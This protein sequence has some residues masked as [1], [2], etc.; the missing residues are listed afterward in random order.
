M[1]IGDAC[2]SI[3][4]ANKMLESIAGVT[5]ERNDWF[6]ATHTPIV[7]RVEKNE[8]SQDKLF[9]EIFSAE[10][11]EFIAVVR[12]DQGSGK[13]QLIRWLK[14]RY[15]IEIGERET[16][17]VKTRTVMI[18]RRSGSLKDALVQMCEQLPE[19]DQYL[20]KVKDA[21][22]NLSHTEARQRLSSSMFFCLQ[23]DVS[24]APSRLLRQLHTV[25]TNFG[26]MEHLIREG[27][28]IDLN[29]KRLVSQRRLEDEDDV[30]LPP[31]KP[32]DFNFRNVRDL[33]PDLWDR[34][35][36]DE[37]Q[38]EAAEWSTKHLRDA[39][40]N[41]TGLQKD[42]LNLIFRDIRADLKS[43]NES[44]VLFIEDV[45]TLGVLD[46]ELVN[47]VQPT[48]DSKLCPMVSVLGMTNGT[49]G[50]LPTNLLD[51]I[52]LKIELEIGSGFGSHDSSGD[53]VDKFVGRYLNALRYD[54]VG[55]R[56]LAS[57]IRNDGE[58]SQSKCLNCS[59]RETCF[60]AFGSVDIDSIQVGLYPLGVGTSRR[61]LDGLSNPNWPR[62]PR[63][64]I[65]YVL[66]KILRSPPSEW[67]QNPIHGLPVDLESPV[68]LLAYE[69]TLLESWSDVQKDNLNLLVYYWTGKNQ[70]QSAVQD[71]E[72]KLK[73]WALPPFGEL[74]SQTPTST[75]SDNSAR[76]ERR[77]I[78]GPTN[79]NRY[80]E[81]IGHLTGWSQRKEKLQ[82]P[83]IFRDLLRELIKNSVDVSSTRDPS[84]RIRQERFAKFDA[85]NIEIEDSASQARIKTPLT[86]NFPRN[87]ETFSLLRHLLAYRYEGGD[88]WR[89]SG[90]T[91]GRRLYG[92]WIRKNSPSVIASISLPGS[93]PTQSVQ[94]S[95][96]FLSF[97]Y[98]FL[99]RID[100]PSDHANATEKFISFD[101]SE[102]GCECFT[103]EL[104]K[105]ANELPN[106]VMD[107]RNALLE[108]LSV[109]QDS[110]NVTYIDPRPI[111]RGLRQKEVLN[112]LSDNNDINE[113]F[114]S[115]LFQ[116][117]RYL[118]NLQIVDLLKKEVDQ[119]L[120]RHEQITE[121]Y[122]YWQVSSNSFKESC[123]LFL[124]DCIDLL[125]IVE[126]AKVSTGNDNL[127]RELAGM[128][129]QE[130]SKR[131]STLAQVESL[132]R[133]DP[134]SLLKC[135][136]IG[137][138]QASEFI[139]D[140]DKLLKNLH[141]S[142]QSAG[143]SIVT[144]SQVAEKRYELITAINNFVG[145]LA[146]ETDNNAK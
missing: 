136:I 20:S 122:S 101:V 114:F 139:L 3:S 6:L 71:L 74:K 80:D 103:E 108:E 131:A 33:D 42:T 88:S 55:I 46:R 23:D 15:D 75:S 47:A 91:E 36:D 7:C 64:L 115:A 30:S 135:S 123:E 24:N 11:Q 29:I 104:Q 44:L 58:I 27:G 68:D 116:T 19:C 84:Y 129:T 32:E 63:N 10:T 38:R 120:K 144:S 92:R 112:F 94:S 138:R 76:P 124:N 133:D 106:K 65:L 18:R 86:F 57:D 14:H 79:E 59:V 118:G 97:A 13:S 66:K 109:P 142:S 41:L 119:I 93:D 69:R 111:L 90:G 100:F 140:V 117:L 121:I 50:N 54:E 62:T 16:G 137:Y 70:L 67:V 8:Y 40:S 128:T 53:I 51:R 12:G 130:I 105:F 26:S 143:I 2:W 39:I 21:I 98:R 89:Y 126:V 113:K 145:S 9:N 37:A 77:V 99:Y 102:V 17:S 28:A 52:N 81:L 31:F 43:R 146:T 56:D 95:I 35:Q 72:K 110:R 73:W 4:F 34:L 48:L 127:H 87:A 82:Q 96:S 78:P 107:V 132:D 22:G 141:Q 61:L 125:K 5:D 85:R 49:F 1:N 134:V 25:F 60:N 83:Q 45:S